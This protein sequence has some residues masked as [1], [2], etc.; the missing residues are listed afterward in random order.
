VIET[1]NRIIATTICANEYK[2]NI[3]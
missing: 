3:P 2:K 1:T